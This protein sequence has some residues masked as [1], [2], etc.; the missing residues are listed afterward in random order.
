MR[1]FSIIFTASVL[2]GVLLF[3]VYYRSQSDFNKDHQEILEQFAG[4]KQSGMALEKEVL[5]VQ[6]FIPYNDKVYV[7]NIER[8]RA[9]CDLTVMQYFI[10]S[11][12]STYDEMFMNY[13]HEALNLI[14]YLE[15]F[16]LKSDLYFKAVVFL[17][18]EL[19]RRLEKEVQLN[20]KSSKQEIE[21]IGAALIYSFIP[22]EKVRKNIDSILIKNKKYLNQNTSDKASKNIYYSALEIVKL[23]YELL[24]LVDSIMA[25]SSQDLADKLRSLYFDDYKKDQHLA[26]YFRNSL[27][28]ISIIL[29]IFF[30]LNNLRLL[31]SKKDLQDLNSNLEQ[32]VAVRTKELRDSQTEIVKQQ[33]TLVTTSKM[34]ALGEMASG[35]AHEINT[36]LA[37]IQMRNSQLIDFINDEPFDKDYA[38]A[39][40]GKIDHTVARISKIINGLVS[41][42]RDGKRDAMEQAS[43]LKII[44][45][46]FDLC[47]ERFK[48]NNVK[49][50]LIYSNDAIIECHPTEIAQ[51]LLNFLNNSFDAIQN[52]SDKW[53]NIELKEIGKFIEIEIT[54]CG[55]GIP[56]DI[57]DKIMQPFFTTKGVGKGT[58]LGL[59]ISNNIIE[60]HNGTVRIDNECL[61]TRF[62]ISFPISKLDLPK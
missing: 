8:I 56:K 42:A 9:F 52:F 27:F 55:L 22:S 36:P 29:F 1:H 54:D 14:S 13:R 39:M 48:H 40:L 2:G 24:V 47:R 53:I 23:K 62:I 60:V 35:V 46:T 34:S 7:E 25:S 51:V 10:N 11:R 43:L 21:V 12:S 15:E 17:R 45:D 50:E 5:G 49:I 20:L 3:Y 33:Q 4:I 32:R 44:N 57:Q 31:K 38:L 61:N 6:N 30:I 41:F 59:S 19:N 18:G 28:L 37:I 58:G 26:T 16:K